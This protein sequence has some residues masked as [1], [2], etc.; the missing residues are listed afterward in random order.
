MKPKTIK[1]VLRK[2]F[3]DFCMSIKDE[4]VRE[5]VMKNS[6]ITG[7]SIASML[8]REP[9]N[10]FDIYFKNAETV[11]AVANYYIEEFSNKNG[12]AITLTE[13]VDDLDGITR[14]KIKVQSVGIAAEE[15]FDYGEGPDEGPDV[16]E[17][18]SI[19]PEV[20]SSMTNPEPRED[21]D[22]ED[23]DTED[24][25]KENDSKKLPT[26][27]PVYLSSNAITL[28]DKVQ[29]I[30]RFYGSAE[31]I[32]KNYDFVHCT[33]YW[34]SDTGK[35]TLPS[36]ALAA[37]LSRELIYRGSRY[38]L[39]SIIRSRKFIQRGFTINAG[40]YLKM[41]IQLN[42]LD[43]TKLSVLE[44]QLTGVDA[45]YFVNLLHAIPEKSIIDGSVDSEYI[46]T[47][48]DRFF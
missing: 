27:R 47:L 6:I 38:P 24:A 46:I 8:L 34:E 4:K 44:D 10:D 41:C 40:Q 3:N 25:D 1:K 42:S 43:L 21:A 37:L 48:V 28:S 15:G 33:C 31:E 11:K 16:A 13:T 35:L 7:G 12:F 19:Y 23:A 36:E 30:I 39:A 14:Y 22:T 2:K 18:P 32:H 17:D 26:Y 45:Y 5:L 9:V 29:L 20:T